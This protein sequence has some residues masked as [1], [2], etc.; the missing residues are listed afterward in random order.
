MVSELGLLT[1]TRGALCLPWPRTTRGVPETWQTPPSRFGDP[2]GVWDEAVD[3][4]EL[5]ATA[6]VYLRRQQ[7]LS[8]TITRMRRALELSIV[9][10]EFV[11]E[12][13]PTDYSTTLGIND[14]CNWVDQGL[15]LTT[16]PQLNGRKR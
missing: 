9:L 10:R 4:D 1:G 14:V 2:L 6:L 12:G 5:G 13:R 11:R 15:A 16:A 3:E 8:E 7:S